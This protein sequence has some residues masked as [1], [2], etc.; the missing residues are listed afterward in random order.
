MKKKFLVACGILLVGTLTVT[1]CT[2]TTLTMTTQVIS[3]STV[4]L[5]ETTY[6]QTV[7]SADVKDFLTG[8]KS[9]YSEGTASHGQ[10]RLS[11]ISES[12]FFSL[13]AQSDS[14]M[15]MNGTSYNYV[16]LSP[17]THTSWELPAEVLLNN[18]QID[19]TVPKVVTTGGRPISV[20]IFTGDD[21]GVP[22]GTT[23]IYYYIPVVV[24]TASV[25]VE[26]HTE[27][28]MQFLFMYYYPYPSSQ[29][30]DNMWMIIQPIG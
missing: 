3:T 23:F 6:T 4:T 8:I 16:A 28:N 5:P 29:V 18:T 27:G 7:N 11:G 21:T 20:Q 2:T 17:M 26:R 9:V 15:S 10:P 14:V 13:K 25:S 12:D 19:F 1:S 24:T 22:F 30:Q